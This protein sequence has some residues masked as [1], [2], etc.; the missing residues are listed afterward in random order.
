MS[1]FLE[2]IQSLYRL[3]ILSRVQKDL[4][5]LEIAYWHKNLNIQIY[6]NRDDKR[7]YRNKN[8]ALIRARDKKYYKSPCGKL[9][10]DLAHNQYKEKLKFMEKNIELFRLNHRVL[11]TT[12]EG[13]E[14]F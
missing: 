14:K 1:Y 9:A 6:K 3:E 10:K 7:R 5:S 12:K 2:E 11:Y 13:K 8:R 4:S